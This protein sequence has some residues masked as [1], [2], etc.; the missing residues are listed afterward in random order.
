MVPLRRR[1]L[2]VALM[3]GDLVVV[4]LSFSL[5]ALDVS[6]PRSGV[7]LS[8][9]LAMRLSIHNFVLF[10]A[11]LGGWH[12]IFSASG[13][14][15]SRRLTSKWSET[16]DVLRATSVG[17]LVTLVVSVI[18]RI[19]VVTPSF[20]VVF[21]ATTSSVTVLGRFML[22]CVLQRIRLA[23]RN[24]R[25]V[26]IV[27]T[28]SRALAFAHLIATQRGHGY[29][30]IGFADDEWAGLGDVKSRDGYRLVANLNE[31]GSFLRENVIDEVVIALPLKSLY[32]QAS[33]IVALCE[34][35]GIVVRLLPQVF[36]LRIA[37]AEIEEI[38]GHPTATI[39]CGGMRGWPV[40]AKRVLDFCGALFLLILLSPLF[41]LVALA[42]KLRSPGPVLFVQERV[43]LNK[44]LFRLYKFR[45]MIPD[46]ELKH[47][48]VAHLNEATGP[49]FKI[50]NDPRITRVGRFLRRTSIDELPQLVNVLKGDM[51]LVG[52]RPLPVRDYQGFDEDWQRRRFSVCPGIT[53]L[54]QVEGRSSLT[55]D[56]WMKLDLHYIDNWSLWL[57]AKIL[58]KTIPA[59]LKGSGA[60]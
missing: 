38:E 40:G 17:A 55:F 30:L 52:P 32:A 34:E 21:W 60:H 46:A 6:F 44:R 31:V 45:T 1:L 11:L 50:K 36:S 49:V 18:F 28:N 43:G 2:L 35:Q 22:R 58:L 47:A 7:S 41:L 42:I 29:R 14:Y 27:G 53:C 8:D 4:T 54:W 3:L 39:Y 23:G 25:H 24:L 33:Y 9:F 48:E 13:L 5:T 16:T 51:S 37:R 20:L 10:L 57:D 59:V 12:L 56:R 19:S 15:R 26:L